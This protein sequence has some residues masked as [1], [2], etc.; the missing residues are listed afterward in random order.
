MTFLYRLTLKGF[1]NNKIIIV[2]TLFTGKCGCSFVN[3][4]HNATRR[5]KRGVGQQM[6][7]TVIDMKL[8]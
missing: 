2:V 1:F 3:V 6:V 4:L 8:T 5:L 7:N